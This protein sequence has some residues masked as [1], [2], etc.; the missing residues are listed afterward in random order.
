[1]IWGIGAKDIRMMVGKKINPNWKEMIEMENK[2]SA[3]DI[4]NHVDQLTLHV[5]NTSSP[6]RVR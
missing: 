6:R 3:H 5:L 1:M 4:D 2:R